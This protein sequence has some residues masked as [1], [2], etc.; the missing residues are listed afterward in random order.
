MRK[1]SHKQVK[2]WILVVCA[3]IAEHAIHFWNNT[4]NTLVEDNVIINCDRG[5]GFGMTN[6]PNMG[7]LLL[8]A[9]ACGKVVCGVMVPRSLIRPPWVVKRGKRYLAAGWLRGGKS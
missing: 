7:G 5:I 6:R 3:R 9:E 2:V 4:Q 1:F 8:D